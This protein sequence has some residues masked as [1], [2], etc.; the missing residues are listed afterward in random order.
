M[1]LSTRYL[2]MISNLHYSLLHFIFF[3]VFRRSNIKSIL[4]QLRWR[5]IEHWFSC[6]FVH[7]NLDAWNKLGSDDKKYLCGSMTKSEY[8]GSSSLGISFR[9]SGGRIGTYPPYGYWPK[10][11]TA[12]CADTS[13]ITVVSMEVR[14]SGMSSLGHQL[15]FLWSGCPRLMNSLYQD[16]S[17]LSEETALEFL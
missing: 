16:W 12:C 7:M 6:W 13:Q 3:F 2:Q 10:F 17:S 1:L 11:K 5:I 4:V 8:S 9:I 14:S 15:A